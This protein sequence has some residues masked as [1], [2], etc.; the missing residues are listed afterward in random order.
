[1]KIFRCLLT[2]FLIALLALTALFVFTWRYYHDL[3]IFLYISLLID[4][5]GVVPYRDLYEYNMPGTYF[6]CLLIGKVTGYSE[7]GVRILDYVLVAVMIVLGGIWMR[8]LNLWAGLM[9]GV[10]WALAYFT[11]GPTAMIQREYMMLLPILAGLAAYTTIPAEQSVTRMF[12]TGLLLGSAATIKPQGFV[13]VLPIAWIE[14]QAAASESDPSVKRRLSALRRNL[15]WL[16]IGFL[17]PIAAMFLY[18]GINGALPSFFEIIFNYLPLFAQM[19]INHQTVSGVR[20]IYSVV[21][22]FVKLGGYGIWLAPALWGAYLIQQTADLPAEKKR[23]SMLLTVYVIAFAVY[24]VFSGQFF[25][26]HWLIFAFFLFQAAFVCLTVKIP[27]PSAVL[28]WLPAGLL[29]I[30]SL[31]LVRP[32]T[33]NNLWLLTVKHELPAANNPKEGRVDEIAAFLKTNLRPGDI[34]QPIDWVG[35]AVHAML[36]V[37]VKMATPFIYDEYFYHHVNNPY[38]Q[39]LRQRFVEDLERTRPRFVI[40]VYDDGPFSEPTGPNTS[41]DFPELRAFLAENYS[42]VQEGQGYRI[43]ELLQE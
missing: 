15:L 14:W 33:L 35:G 23:Y 43:Y 39:T 2:A 13:G 37:R 3:P 19:D 12:V 32:D 1:M 20:R 31:T 25:P 5:F 16:G 30:A 4:K 40:E 10:A 36:M 9:G 21:L 28:R 42:V 8:K 29:M 41:R 38:V 18:L 24:P 17:S 34:V 22:E 26:Q 6:A 7:M 11:L 27:S